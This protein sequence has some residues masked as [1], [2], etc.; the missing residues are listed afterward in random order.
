MYR[1]LGTYIKAQGNS[2]V[3]VKGDVSVRC[4][5]VA[6]VSI[7]ALRGY[8]VGRRG[9]WRGLGGHVHGGYVVGGCVGWWMDGGNIAGGY[10]SW[11]IRG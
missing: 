1:A 6:G 3:Y 8:C 10:M 4:T 2:G 7:L 9:A 5:E 11:W